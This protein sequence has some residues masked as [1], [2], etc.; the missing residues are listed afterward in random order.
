M[1]LYETDHSREWLILAGKALAHLAKSRAN[2]S[3]LPPD[4]W[5]LIATAKS[6]RTTTTVLVPF[7]G[8]IWFRMPLAFVI[9]SFESKLRVAA[10]LNSMVAS[11]G[12]GAHRRLLL[13]WKDYWLLGIL[14]G[15]FNEPAFTNQFQCRARRGIPFAGTSHVWPVCRRRS[16]RGSESRFR[17]R[18]GGPPCGRD[19]NRLRTACVRCLASLPDTTREPD[20]G[21][22]E[23]MKMEKRDQIAWSGKGGPGKGGPGKGGRPGK[24]GTA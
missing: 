19:S 20:Q 6:C 22:A 15:G 10:M 21:V 14:A 5:A 24:G 9:G 2:A 13:G 7:P 12:V 1:T 4:H 11:T 16:T 17:D 3:E 18:Q 8:R 23:K